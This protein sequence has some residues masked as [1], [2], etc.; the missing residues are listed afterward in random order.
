MHFRL[1]LIAISPPA[2]VALAAATYAATPAAAGMVPQDGSATFRFA[3]SVKTPKGTHSGSGTIVVKRTG[4]RAV[5]LTVQSDDGKPSHTIPLIIGIDG[6]VAPDPAAANGASAATDADTKAQAQA[7]MAEMTVAAH[8][9]IN[10]RKN[11]GGGSYD[12]PVMLT[13]VGEGTPV[14]STLSMTGSAAQFTGST[15]AETT[16]KLPA[17]GSLDPAQ[18]AKTIGVTAVAHHAFTPIGRAAT[19]VVMHH[20]RKEEKKAASGELPDAMTLTVTAELADG[21]IHQ[22]RGAQTDAIALPGK[23]VKIESSWTF[24]NAAN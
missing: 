21:K 22:I 19:V 16:T 3:T 7:F 17:G 4:P 13:P 8:V 11:A 9:G 2:L 23:P 15:G 6:S 14:S 20:K 10:A 18:I 5:S 1:V 24:T 12:V